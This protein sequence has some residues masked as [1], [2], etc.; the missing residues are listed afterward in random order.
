V[1]EYGRHGFKIQEVSRDSKIFTVATN[2]IFL[3]GVVEKGQLRE[4]D[5][6]TQKE[7]ENKA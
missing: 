7:P 3:R 5:K 1:P 6:F 4:I 2:G